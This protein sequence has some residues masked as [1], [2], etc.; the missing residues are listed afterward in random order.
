MSAKAYEPWTPPEEQ[1]RRWER[2]GL[3]RDLVEGAAWG[4][5]VDD[6]V[7][8]IRRER[9]VA[10]VID[11]MSQIAPPGYFMGLIRSDDGEYI[12]T[13]ELPREEGRPDGRRESQPEKCGAV[14][15]EVSGSVPDDPAKWADSDYWEDH[16]PCALPSG[17][18]GE[19]RRT[20]DTELSRPLPS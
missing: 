11:A 20:D 1:R 18:G 19:H 12:G 5:P 10:A 16:Y 14:I 2:L 3:L 6:R 8:V 13:I 7:E 4:R 15:V 17:H 9:R